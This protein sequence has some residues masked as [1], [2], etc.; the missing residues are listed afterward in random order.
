M[1]DAAV[2]SDETSNGHADPGGAPPQRDLRSF[3]AE[4]NDIQKEVLTIR[5]WGDIQLEVRGMTGA[6]RA[7]YV[8]VLNEL[9][10]SDDG[11][12]MERIYPAL[13]IQTVFDPVSGNRVFGDGDEDMLNSKAGKVLER[14]A[15]S[16]IKLSGMGQNDEDQAGK[17][18][19]SPEN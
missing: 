17:D 13:I 4:F 19:S 15:Q 6:E 10:E 14:L 7:H 9:Q 12:S 3:I 2:F 16:A 18:S 5:E 8:N 11:D 1:S